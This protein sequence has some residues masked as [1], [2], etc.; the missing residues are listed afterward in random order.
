MAMPKFSHP[1]FRDV[2][3]AWQQCA[4]RKRGGHQAQRFEWHLLDEIMDLADS[5]ERQQWR[6]APPVSF[7]LN[8]VKPREVH[9]AEFKDRV[10]H[11]YLV[12]QLATLYEPVFI[13]DVH[14]NRCGKGTHS[15]VARLT[16][17]LR[18]QR[19][20]LPADIDVGHFL[21]LDIK[22]FFNCIDRPV[23]FGLLQRRL[24]KAV[25]QGKLPAEEAHRL[26]YLCHTILKQDAAAQARQIAQPGEVGRLPAHKRLVNA[27]PNKG[28]PIGNLTS[29][30][31]ANVVLNELD[32][33][34][35]HELKCKHYVRYV[36]DFVLLADR[37]A[38]LRGWREQIRL[39]LAQRLRLSLRDSGVLR[40]VSNGVDFLGY[41]VR[42]D[43][44]LVRRR[45]VVNCRTKLR[46]WQKANVSGNGD[47]G[48][49]VCVEPKQIRGLNAMLSSYL[50]HFSHA[51]HHR[52][53]HSLVFTEFP[54]LPLLFD[55]VTKQ[56]ADRTFTTLALAI[57]P[58]SVSGYA[59]QC[60][61]FARRFPN[62]AL[63]VQKGYVHDQ[64]SALATT[65]AS[66]DSGHGPVVKEQTAQ[67]FDLAPAQQTNK[68]SGA[69]VTA[70]AQSLNEQATNPL[71]ISVRQQQIQAM[72]LRSTVSAVRVCE[73][74]LLKKGLKRRQLRW[75]FTAG[76][77]RSEIVAVQTYQ[78]I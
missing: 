70:P 59:A 42:A 46:R 38:T 6:P 30:F 2:F 61:W 51:N 73:N 23:L 27:G 76:L 11:H 66:A 32:Q 48:W 19:A 67:W 71:Y 39:F 21:Q 57:A 78:H 63:S 62:A 43:Y 13:Y 34:V 56:S 31:F 3:H 1:L 35:K 17:F 58:T 36:D 55:V 9:A 28:L 64:F 7:V 54:W 33:F 10:V 75:L 5:I 8:Q 74:G 45:V 4:K 16:R 14:S 24:R 77:A 68:S 72:R 18:Q 49:R 29:Q 69:M 12:P 26:R 20:T 22:N 50:A 15:A 25:Q 53:L 52:L 47:Y 44:R 40:P 37:A 41:I 60:R 65:V